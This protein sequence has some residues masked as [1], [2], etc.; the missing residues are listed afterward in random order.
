[1]IKESVNQTVD[2]M[3]FHN[4]LNA[5]FTLHQLNHS[6]WA[7]VNDAYTD[8]P[9]STEQVIHPEKYLAGEPPIRILVDAG[10]S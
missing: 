4:S 6:H 1:M 5:C 2:N 10:R 3:G 9:V 8:A 7:Q